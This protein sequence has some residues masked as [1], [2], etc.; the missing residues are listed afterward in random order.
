MQ[1]MKNQKTQSS[2]QQMRMITRIR[3]VLEGE[4]IKEASKEEEEEEEE[5]KRTQYQP[6]E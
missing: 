2:Y 5:E 6:V 1:L 4:G 3:V